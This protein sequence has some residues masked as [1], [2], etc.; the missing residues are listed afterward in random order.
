MPKNDTVDPAAAARAARLRDQIK[1]LV[2]APTEVDK[3]VR[4]PDAKPSD[5]GGNL[6]PH[7]FIQRRMRDLDRKK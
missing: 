4:S 7:E 1:E 2:N 3:G 5:I 6:S